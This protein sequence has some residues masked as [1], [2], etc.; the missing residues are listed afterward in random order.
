MTE[1][2]SNSSDSLQEESDTSSTA[3]ELYREHKDVTDRIRH[4]EQNLVNENEQEINDFNTT[5]KILERL[6]DESKSF[7]QRIDPFGNALD[8]NREALTITM[9]VVLSN[10]DRL[11]DSKNRYENQNKTL[12]EKQDANLW[13]SQQHY[14]ENE[15]A[16]K[17]QAIKEAKAAGKNILY[18]AITGPVPPPAQIKPADSN[19]P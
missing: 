19:T 9:D 1:Q 5:R 2:A 16:Y 18:P 6:L 10:M 13:R 8:K 7:P 3:K 4:H 14:R 15:E 17:E 12:K 11:L